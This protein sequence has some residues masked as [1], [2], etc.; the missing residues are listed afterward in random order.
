M[1]THYNSQHQIE[2]AF[3]VAAAGRARPL[4]KMKGGIVFVMSMREYE[5]RHVKFRDRLLVVPDF[6]KGDYVG[7]YAGTGLVYDVSSDGLYLY[8][9]WDNPCELKEKVFSFNVGVYD[10]H[11]DIIYHNFQKDDFKPITDGYL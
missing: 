1:K 8:V 3:F 9:H 2:R 10:K 5:A 11:N 7:C 4:M 6:K